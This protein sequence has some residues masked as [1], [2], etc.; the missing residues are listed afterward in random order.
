MVL[1]SAH[2]SCTSILMLMSFYVHR[3][4]L[5]TF[6]CHSFWSCNIKWKVVRSCHPSSIKH[7]S[8]LLRHQGVNPCWRDAPLKHGT[9]EEWKLFCTLWFLCEIIGILLVSRE[10]SPQK[11][12]YRSHYYFLLWLKLRKVISFQKLCYMR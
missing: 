8:V 5:I 2:W 10:V 3:I 11:S 7:L 12:V 6:Y 1:L 4:F 9:W